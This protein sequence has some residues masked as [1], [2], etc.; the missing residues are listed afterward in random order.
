MASS[1]HSS[2]P[3]GTTA[4][5]SS[6]LWAPGSS[7]AARARTAS[8]TVAG[9][10]PSGGEDLRDEERVAGR[11]F[12]EVAAVVGVRVP[13]ERGDRDAGEGR[14][15]DPRRTL[16]RQLPERD[17]QRMRPVELVVTVGGDDEG[18]EVVEPAGQEPEDVEG[19]GVGPVE[20]LEDE[21]RRGQAVRAG[22]DR[23]RQRVDDLRGR[24]LLGDEHREVAAG[25]LGD[26]GERPE[27]PRGVERVAGAR[28][29]PR[30]R[31]LGREG[32]QQRRL[33]DPGLAREEDE[34]AAALAQRRVVGVRERGELL[35]AFEKPLGDD[36]RLRCV[37][38]H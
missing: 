16:A 20:V 29:D 24:R 26:V 32:A 7:R 36:R 2:A 13:D 21:D 6:T 11:A 8:R 19:G 4:T 14:Q 22:L 30:L 34:P 17:P 37:A 3:R 38:C 33:P 9:T 5:A 10:V 35:G 25:L 15:G 18:R 12:V 23:A 28:E 31:M 1:S 27:R